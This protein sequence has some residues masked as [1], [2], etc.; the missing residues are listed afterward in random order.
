MS[1]S[2]QQRRTAFQSL[3]E[4]RGFCDVPSYKRRGRTVKF[5]SLLERRGFCDEKI[6]EGA[7]VENQ[8]FNLS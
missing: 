1:T 4:R 8:S 6:E 2:A 5:Q 7:D 3:L